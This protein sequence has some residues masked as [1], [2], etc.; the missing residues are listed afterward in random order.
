VVKVIR[1][2]R[3]QAPPTAGD[4]PDDGREVALVF[5]NKQQVAMRN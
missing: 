4:R 2:D 5:G 1:P 3:R